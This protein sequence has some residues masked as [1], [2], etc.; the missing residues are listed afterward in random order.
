MRDEK[1]TKAQLVDELQ[2]LRH[3]LTGLQE[4][5]PEPGRGEEIIKD[6]QIPYLALF[7]NMLD[8]YAYCR[9]ITD[10]NNKPVDFVHIKVNDAYERLTGLKKREVT[11]KRYSEII[12]ATDDVE[13]DLPSIYGKV[14]LTGKSTKFDFYFEPLKAW[15]SVFAYSPRSGDFAVIFDNITRRRRTEQALQEAY[16]ELERRVEERTAELSK[17]N[18]ALEQEIRERKEVEEQLKQR[19]ASERAI[20][21]ISSRF[22]DVSDIDE[23]INISLAEMGS[24]AHA[25]RAYVFLFDENQLTA[26]NTHE[27]CAEGVNPQID[28]L[29][30]VPCQAAPWWMERLNKGET[31]YIEDV[32]NL[33]DEAG[34]EKEI[35]Q[36][37]DIKSL[38]VFPLYAADKLAGFTGF[39]NVREAGVWQHDSHVLRHLFSEILGNAIHR[40]WMQAQAQCQQEELSYVA[41]LHTLGQMVGGLAH[42]IN[43]PLASIISSA[44][45]ASRM[46]KSGKENS[47]KVSRTLTRVVLQA[48]R[49]G[50]IIRRL[51]KLTRRQKPTRSTA[52][53]KTI[54]HDAVSLIGAEARYN[55]VKISV[56]CDDQIPA[57]LVDS[58]QIQ[59]VLLNL[60]R[61]AF[62]AMTCSDQ[63]ELT[64]QTT[65]VEK[66][67][68]QVTV[69]DT[70]AGINPEIFGKIFEPFFTSKPKGLGIG[71][72]ISKTIIEAHGGR[73]W[74]TPNPV[75]GVTFSFTLPIIR[76]NNHES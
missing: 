46:V 36:A 57:I 44:E 49:A 31:I 53:L 68:A 67:V 9:I 29:R 17:A 70:G 69:R 54:V 4:L 15:F 23:A 27:W 47:D 22:I 43:Q 73:L 64:I 3:R 14:A 19:L 42:E 8:G 12:P 66:N 32:S 6:E 13:P 37:Q 16:D 38:L 26:T 5:E 74:A 75:C 7:N 59:Q 34:A 48:E 50:E 72:S 2:Q 62:E 55:G 45:A 35:L 52:D 65:L 25:D 39:D 21:T 60:A 63:R 33:P 28:H 41:R 51:K 20:L 71:L 11:G 18:I 58:I 1:K 30:N 76:G 24:L 61:N 40:K 56:E 10:E